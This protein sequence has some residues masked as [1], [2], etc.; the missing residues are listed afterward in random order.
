LGIIGECFE[1]C[2]VNNVSDI[3][4]SFNPYTCIISRVK[5]LSTPPLWFKSGGGIEDFIVM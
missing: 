3:Y 4:D 5:Y 2:G 1:E